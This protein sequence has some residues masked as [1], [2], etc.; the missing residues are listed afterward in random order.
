[1]YPVCDESDKEISVVEIENALVNV[2]D[3]NLT[4]LICLLIN[5]S[6]NI[7]VVCSRYYIRCLIVCTSG[8][9]RL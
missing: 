5:I 8:G 1:M 4:V 6:M 9:L 2:N 7:H 3:L